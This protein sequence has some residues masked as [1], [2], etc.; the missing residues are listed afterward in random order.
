MRARYAIVAGVLSALA[1][2]AC[3]STPSGPTNPPVVIA[4]TVVGIVP[5]SG[6][7]A[8]GT[9]V[10]ISGANF[11]SGATV[12][13]GG[14]AA[15]N[16][17]VSSSTTILATTGAHPAGAAE[18]TVS[19]NGQSSTLS[20]GFTYVTTPPPTITSIAPLSGTTA[21]GTTVTVT[22]TNFA[23]GATLTI[24]GAAATAVAVASPTSLQAVT[25][26]R[27]LG[28]A[29]VVV[30]VGGQS[31]TLARGF[32]FVTP[33]PNLP[34]AITSMVVQ[35]P[36]PG[37]PTD[38]A[39][40]NEDV[41]VTAVVTD[42]ETPVSQLAFAWTA[43]VGTFTGSGPAV[44]WRA[45]AA[46]ATPRAVTLTLK[47][48]ETLSGGAGSQS[49]TG[50]V[51]LTLHDSVKEI[52]DMSRQF[53][54]DFSDSKLSPSYVVRDFWDGCPGKA[55][56][57]GDVTTN[58]KNFLILSS[59]IGAANPVSVGFTAGCVV[60][61]RPTRDGDGCAVVQ[62]EW[63]DKELSTGTLGT[64]K[65]PD[66]LTAVFRSNRWWLCNSDFPSGTRTNPVTGAAFIR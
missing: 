20:P 23:A 35:S 65:G 48:T 66:Y 8:G 44:R 10:T 33:G 37:A 29:D 40:L 12:S 52:G 14:V 54:L 36:R 15:T 61:N 17:R 28:A 51:T 6:S 58:R 64:T 13:I 4:P 50:K 3:G 56:E 62:C 7:T 30:T 9:E 38:F 57:L 26:A 11:A 22:G 55:D 2:S 42:A 16:V 34:P 49:S 19:V 31:A 5:A 32:T 18:V 46:A 43:D 45:P 59:T 39:D 60:P 27:P 24:G 1:L 25:P 41:A 47:V 21:G 53:L 63:H